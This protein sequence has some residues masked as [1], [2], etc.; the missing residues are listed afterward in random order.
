MICFTIVP[1]CCVRQYRKAL[2]LI[3]LFQCRTDKGS[4]Q[5][6]GL[7]RAGLEFRME[8]Y[9]DKPR[10][11]RQGNDLYQT[12]V[13][14]KSGDLQ[15]LFGQLLAEVIVEFKPVAVTLIDQVFAVD[16]VSACTDTVPDAWCRPWWECLSGLP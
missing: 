9:A 4:E 16:L 8:L 12:F 13:R 7:V 3:P 10:V 6:L 2:L 11:I 5:L 14:R 1:G 15:A